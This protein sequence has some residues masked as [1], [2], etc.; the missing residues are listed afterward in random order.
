MFI[1]LIFSKQTDTERRIACLQSQPHWTVKIDCANVKQ[2]A[3]VRNLW[4]AVRQL[5]TRKQH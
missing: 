5:S 2:Q 3:S 4:D 1:D